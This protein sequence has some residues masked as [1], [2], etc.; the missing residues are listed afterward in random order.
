LPTFLHLESQFILQ[1]EA[2]R[3]LDLRRVKVSTPFSR[4]LRMSLGMMFAQAAAHQRR[5]LEQATRVFHQLP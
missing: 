3:G 5:H 1:A 2:A 4:F